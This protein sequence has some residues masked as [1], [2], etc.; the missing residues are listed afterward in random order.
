MCTFLLYAAINN[1]ICVLR[2]SDCCG[3]FDPGGQ[4]AGSL[5]VITDAAHV[6]V[7]LMSLLI[8]LLSLRLSSKSPIKRLT[9]G[10]H[11]AGRTILM[12]HHQAKEERLLFIRLMNGQLI[13]GFQFVCNALLTNT[14]HALLLLIWV[15]ID[16]TH[17]RYHDPRLNSLLQGGENGQKSHFLPSILYSI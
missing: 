12:Q 16:L 4:I 15:S 7:D 9:Y 14:G 3:S 8:S 17:H 11:R 1:L 6:L 10:W 5:A 2:V 13:G